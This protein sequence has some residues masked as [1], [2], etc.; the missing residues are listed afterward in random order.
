MQNKT[1]YLA[2]FLFTILSCG[3]LFCQTDSSKKSES[4]GHTYRNAT[5][6]IS[7]SNSQIRGINNSP[8]QADKTFWYRVLDK[9]D[10]WAL[11]FLTLCIVVSA[12]FQL[13]VYRKSVR[14]DNRAYIGI[15][16]PAINFKQG[17]PLSVSISIRN[18]G[19][20]PALN[21]YE[22]V[23]ILKFSNDESLQDYYLKNKE[24]TD[25]NK[26][27]GRTLIPGMFYIKAY[28]P[29]LGPPRENAV[30][31]IQIKELCIIGRVVYTDIYHYEHYVSFCF[32]YDVGSERF[33]AYHKYN[34]AD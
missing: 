16:S 19:K 24:N 1:V 32:W 29:D 5:R 12:I 15:D 25:K 2:I 30:A 14:L 20:T 33:L 8:I 9:P 28:S 18:M 27:G 17:K 22:N 34:D 7:D 11:V 26:N 13:C 4:Q 3:N 23:Q 6:E 21:I 31:V 10:Q